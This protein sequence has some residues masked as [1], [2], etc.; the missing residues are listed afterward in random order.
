MR[1]QVQFAGKP[2]G[3]PRCSHAGRS[4]AETSVLFI[5]NSFTYGYGSASR[6]YRADTVTDLNLNGI[7]R[8]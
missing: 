3:F 5:G 4:Y 6:F 8:H 1:R 7:V 2:V